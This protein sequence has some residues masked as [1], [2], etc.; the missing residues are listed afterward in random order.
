MAEENETE[1]ND[2]EREISYHAP[3]REFDN[4]KNMITRI[5]FTAKADEKFEILWP[6]PESDEESQERYDCSL[7]VLI[8]A[9]IRQFSTRPDYKETGFYTD[10]DKENYAQLKPNGHEA[11]QKL[12]DDYKVGARVVG[13]SQ[14]IIVQKVKEAENE[15]GMS[16]AEMV[17]KMKEMKE[18]GLLD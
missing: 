4:T 14:R 3:V 12:A 2:N 7:A 13:V 9:G 10:P 8:Q 1:S 11:M 18:A 16:H 6:I 5:G 15:L 17:A